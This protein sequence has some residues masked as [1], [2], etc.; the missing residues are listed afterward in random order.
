MLRAHA[1]AQG[2]RRPASSGG[3]ERPG[4]RPLSYKPFERLGGLRA[5][6]TSAGLLSESD[7]LSLRRRVAV[8]RVR[9]TV[10][11]VQDPDVDRRRVDLGE[12]RLLCVGVAAPIALEMKTRC[13]ASHSR[14]RPGSARRAVE[15]A[16][17]VCPA[18]ERAPSDVASLMAPRN[19]RSC[20]REGRT[21]AL[22]EGAWVKGKHRP[23]HRVSCPGAG[24]RD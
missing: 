12:V 3:R 18:D 9:P 5:A 2:S 4:R 14:T 19:S 15:A 17:S 10:G 22:T 11:L 16:A 6:L 24:R 7:A 1:R 8:G 13:S 21:L 20:L 23:S